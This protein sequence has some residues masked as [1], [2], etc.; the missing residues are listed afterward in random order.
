MFF[1]LIIFLVFE[2]LSLPKKE[3]WIVILL[4]VM[5]FLVR[6]PFLLHSDGL[7]VTSDNAL[8]A[9]Q[10]QEIMKSHITPFYLLNSIN[11]NGTLFHLLVAFI[12]DLLGTDYL[13]F[14][15]SQIFLYFMFLYLFYK[16]FKN[17]FPEKIIILLLLTQ[18]AFIEIFFNYSLFIRAGQYFQA[19]FFLILS[20]YLFDFSLDNYWRLFFSI[21][22]LTFSLYINPAGIFFAFCF[23]ICVFVR[24]IKNNELMRKKLILFCGALLTGTYHL[25]IYYAFLPKPPPQGSW[26]KIKFIRYLD[27][28]THEV[29]YIFINTFYDFWS[30]FKNLFSFESNYLLTFFQDSISF[31]K[32]FLF[33]NKPLIFL[34]FFIFIFGLAWCIK[35]LFFSKNKKFDKVKFYSL[36]FL[37]LFLAILAKLFLLQPSHFIE[38]RH[39]L[40]LGFLIILSF[41]FFLTEFR[42]SQKYRPIKFLTVI[43]LAFFF[44]IPHYFLFFKN[45]EF[46]ETSYIRILSVLDSNGINALTTDFIIAYPI[47]FLSEQRILVSNSLGPLTIR[48]FYPEMDRKV[49]SLPLDQKA[50][51][52]F[53]KKHHRERW[54]INI[55][56]LKQKELFSLL[57]SS[58]INY[59]LVNLNYYL[60]VIPKNLIR[61]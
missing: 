56:R 36:L 29:I 28:I 1:S 39:H 31:N 33:F 8:E 54:H 14:I 9:L 17:I 26:F 22:F 41:V 38:P 52:F 43:L 4:I 15:I 30:V 40:D 61:H 49:D 55:T 20:L 47:Y 53:T 35:N 16:I 58:G 24:I 11:H 34:S 18:F 3:K 10:S 27:L 5:V 46:K 7:L 21:Y 50:Y 13:T 48:F 37:L 32:L 60:L 45:T 51:L 42:L 44:T 25:I 2:F 59:K 12:W 6:L 19:F 23:L 57:E